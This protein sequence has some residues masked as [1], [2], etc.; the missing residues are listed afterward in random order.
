MASGGVPYD[1]V[2]P[3][4]GEQFVP[5]T[6]V[7]LET[8]QNQI[9]ERLKI[10]M[11]TGVTVE[12]FPDRGPKYRLTNQRAAVL[13]RYD[14]SRYG[15][16]YG[17]GDVAQERTIQWSI[18]LLVRNLGWN[19]GETGN[20]GVYQLIE[21]IRLALTGWW[22]PGM[23]QRLHPLTDTYRNLDEGVWW[24]EAIYAHLV[25]AIQ[26]S[27]ELQTPPLK[28]ATLLLN[29]G[30]GA[31]LTVRSTAGT[32]QF[33]AMD[34]IELGHLNVSGVVVKSMDQFVTYVPIVDY[35]IDS[36]NGKLLRT[37]SGNIAPAAQVL[38]AFDYAEA[39]ETY[40]PS[41]GG[42]PSPTSPDNRGSV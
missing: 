22:I 40:S 26:E 37:P 32:Y 18:Q 9:V 13:I 5:P 23:G 19:F 16:F 2:P 6:K 8:I 38:V 7:D 29:G 34:V 28:R 41:E 20:L 31:R 11:R 33:D 14:S 30:A 42:G 21:D 17:M 15:N 27:D 25:M 4:T 1:R 3:W 12:A 10:R 24:W 36:V 35:A 39:V